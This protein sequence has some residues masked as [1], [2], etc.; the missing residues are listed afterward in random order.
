MGSTS[1]TLWAAV[2][3]DSSW[4]S[5]EFCGRDAFVVTGKTEMNHDCS[6][7]VLDM[8]LFAPEYGQSGSNLSGD[9]D[10]SGSVLPLDLAWLKFCF[11]DSVSPC[12]RSGML[13]D[14][15]EGTIALSFSS[16]P[17][18]I[19]ST[20]TQ[21]PVP[22]EDEG[23]VYV[24]IDGWTDAE[25][26]EYAVETSSNI[27]IVDHPPTGYSHWEVA[28]V[29]LPCD[30]DEQHSWRG[31]VSVTES[32]PTGPIAYVY[33]DY[34]IT[35]ANPAWIK[36]VPVP[37]CWQNS[38]IRW[39]QGAAN[40]SIDFRTVLNVG[41]NG[42]APSGQATCGPLSLPVLAPHMIWLLAA[43]MLA[44]AVLFLGRRSLR[45]RAA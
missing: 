2:C 10:G 16:N 9:F 32:W 34:E 38:R 3:H 33:L 25:I 23:R 43:L 28:D 27:T 8:R 39:A 11:G 44:P 5:G 17:A 40:R 31:F 36:L 41:I 1:Q 42:P 35:D 24:V 37:S 22:P 20:R 4:D 21:S 12:T 30:P 6:V 7:D 18:T 45:R 13:P 29:Q 19:V 26:I 15:C 14:L